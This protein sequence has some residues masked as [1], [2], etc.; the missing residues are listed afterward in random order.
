MD[1]KN[2]DT[3]EGSF[4][5]DVLSRNGDFARTLDV[6]SIRGEGGSFPSTEPY[7]TVPVNEGLE[8]GLESVLRLEYAARSGI[9]SNLE[10]RSWSDSA[11]DT[12]H[13]NWEKNNK[14]GLI[15]I[16]DFRFK[17]KETKK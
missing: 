14:V 11:T 12:D 10:K 13:K 1:R 8:D 3:S 15:S 2:V 17:K 7:T 16:S 6:G 5:S 4:T 9:S